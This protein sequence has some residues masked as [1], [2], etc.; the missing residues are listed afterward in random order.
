MVKNESFNISKAENGY[1]VRCYWEVD[2]DN[3]RYREHSHIYTTKEEVLKYLS[4]SIP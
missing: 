3:D 2:N 1:I 4:A